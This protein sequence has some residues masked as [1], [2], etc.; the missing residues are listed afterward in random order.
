MRTKL[1]AIYLND[2]LAGATAGTAVAQR[3]AGSNRD[4]HAYY[5]TLS[6][7]AEEIR[8]DRASLLGIMSALKIGAD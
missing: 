6:T 5:P 1:L 7:L 4:N 2:H 3:A 8:E